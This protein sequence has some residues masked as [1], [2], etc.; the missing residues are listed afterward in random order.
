MDDIRE[1]ILYIERNNKYKP[2]D[3]A[4]ELLNRWN[5]LKDP[6]VLPEQNNPKGPSFAFTGNNSFQLEG[7]KSTVSFIVKEEY[8]DKIPSIIFDIIDTFDELGV[9]FKRIGYITNTYYP[10]SCI[11][12][13]KQ[14]YLNPKA[15]EDEIEEI[16]LS[17]YRKLDLKEGHINAWERI[18]TDTAAYDNLLVQFDFNTPIH[19]KFEFDMRSIKEFLKVSHDH[20]KKRNKFDI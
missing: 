11:E 15:I 10:N 20:M 1:I 12:K 5:E 13:A 3:A 6:I 8:F 9:S 17:W 16:N 14:I 18:I 4:S 2:V 7:S 19:T